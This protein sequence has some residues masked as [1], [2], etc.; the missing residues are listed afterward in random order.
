MNRKSKIIFKEWLFI[1]LG[2]IGILYLFIFIY[3]VPTACIANEP[4][5]L[6]T[7][8]RLY[9]D[10]ANAAYLSEQEAKK[11]IE[12]Q[13]YRLSQYSNVPGVEVN[14]LVAT[15]DSLKH[16]IIAVRGTANIENAV[17]D[18]SLK[19]LPDEHAKIALHQMKLINKF[20]NHRRITVSD[21][22][23]GFDSNNMLILTKSKKFGLFS[24][25]ERIE[26][27]GGEFNIKSKINV[28]TTATIKIAIGK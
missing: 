17:V 27:I 25:K 13:G 3:F 7:K 14:Y 19:L 16:Q 26:Y 24:I 5:E 12:A 15:N 4:S 20:N 11:T 22:G 21:N 18:I 6:F 1:I 28:G 9:A 2:W 10:M 8:I 23:Q